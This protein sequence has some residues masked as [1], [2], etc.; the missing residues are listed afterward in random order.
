MILAV[1]WPVL[2]AEFVNYDDTDFVTTNPSVVGGL[3]QENVAWAFTSTRVYW[4]PLTWLSYQVD[5]QLHG[6]NPRGFHL[7][8]LV[9]HLLN[10]VLLL[11]ALLRMTGALWRSA[12]VAA[13]FALHPLHVESVA[14]VAERKGLLS[15]LFWMLALLAYAHHA[16]R[17]SWGRFSLVALSYALGLMAKSMIVTLPAVLLLLDVWPLRRVRIS[18]GSAAAGVETTVDSSFPAFTWRG[19]LLEKLF[20]LP[21]AIVS[22]A[23]TIAAQSH[24]GAVWSNPIYTPGMRLAHVVVS[25]VAYLRK[26]FLPFDLTVFYPHPI[27]HPAWLVAVSLALLSAITAVVIWQTR[28]GWLPVGWL[29]FLGTLLPVIGFIQAGD[30][31]MADRYTYIPLIGVFVILAWG[32]FDLLVDQR[33]PRMVL[34]GAATIAIG[35]CIVMTAAQ[36]KTWKNTRTLFEHAVRVSPDNYVGY[37]VLGSLLAQEGRAVEAQQAFE[38]SLAIKPSYFEG[39]T[40]WADTLRAWQRLDEAIFQYREAL[41]VNPSYA[42]ALGGLGSTLVLQGKPEEGLAQLERALQLNPQLHF[43]RIHRALALQSLGRVAEA[44]EQFNLVLRF[45]PGA[46]NSLFGLGNS[47]LAQR[48]FTEAIQCY[49]QLIALQPDMVPALNRLAWLLATHSDDSVRNG[50]D[51]LR[52]ATRACELTANNDPLSL[53]SLAAAYAETGQFDQAVATA[54]RAL[55][56]AT[57][58]GQTQLAGI[59][60]KLVDLYKARTPYRE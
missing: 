5:A 32:G 7:T 24:A 30:Q 10:S 16:A 39:R 20:L 57:T 34:A 13:L 23:L 59:L 33:A 37:A 19:V 1:F 35:F 60:Q 2:N 41:K 18:P 50:T 38:H 31:A 44:N 12:F 56:L 40:V 6:L 46:I 51:A 4:Q 29:W 54:Q 42:D 21:L 49:R 22:S 15:S 11:L 3:T 9:L 58:S 8:N 26:T 27:V 48:R 47:F 14:W 55:D 17:P 36:V 53:N 45:N 52:F 28:R 25:Y 43:A